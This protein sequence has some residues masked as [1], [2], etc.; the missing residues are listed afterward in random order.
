MTTIEESVDRQ[1][2][3]LLEEER[4]AIEAR[5][6]LLLEHI[7]RR[8]DMN[9][10]DRIQDLPLPEAR[11]AQGTSEQPK[12][13]GLIVKDL[14][15]ASVLAKQLSMKSRRLI[16]LYISTP[17]KKAE[18]EKDEAV[19]SAVLIHVLQKITSDLNLS[20]LEISNNLEELE[21]AW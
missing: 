17:Q 18:E 2:K 7:F 10:E 13:F 19:Q 6:G 11:L 16:S 1:R 4:K 15:A 14:T 12:A 3:F 20:L 21:K 5:I 8:N 9:G